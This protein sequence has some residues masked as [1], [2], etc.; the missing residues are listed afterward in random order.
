MRNKPAIL[1]TSVFIHVQKSSSPFAEVR[2]RIT[3]INAMM[4]ASI[5]TTTAR[6]LKI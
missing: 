1:H 5:K 3:E 2:R 4:T 6:L